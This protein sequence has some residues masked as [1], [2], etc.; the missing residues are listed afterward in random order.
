[1]HVKSGPGLVFAAV[2]IASAIFVFATPA[3]PTWIVDCGSG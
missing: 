2:S 1:M 3:E